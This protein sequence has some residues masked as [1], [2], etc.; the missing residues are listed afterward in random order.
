MP[1][2]GRN[3]G[4]VLLSAGW[5]GTIGCSAPKVARQATAAGPVRAL[6]S[7]AAAN[8]VVE[9]TGQAP[10]DQAQHIVTPVDGNGPAFQ[11]VQLVAATETQ[12][13]LPPPPEAVPPATIGETLA[14]ETPE[15]QPVVGANFPT[16]LSLAAGRNPQVAFA[17]SRIVE[18]AAQLQGARAL[19]LPSINVGANYNKH[20]GAIQDV[21]GNMIETTRGSLYSGLGSMAVGASSPAVPGIVARFRLTDA[22][23]EPRITDRLLAANQYGSR[24]VLNDVLLSAGIAYTDLLSA[25][26]FEAIAAETLGHAETLAHLT[27][28]YARTGLGTE[29]D[30]NRLATE[31]AYRRN[32]AQRAREAMQVAS[33]R[34]ARVLSQDPSVLIVPQEPNIFPIDMV[35]AGQSTQELVATALSNR[36]ELA[37]S[38]AL[39]AASVE[40]L[41][42]EVRAPWLP[43]ILLAASYGGNGGGLGDNL[44]RFGDRIDLDAGMWWEIRNSGFGESAARGAARAR[45]DQARAREIQVLDQVASE[46]AEAHVQSVSRR[47][48]IAI[49]EGGVQEAAQS[50][51]RNLQ[52]IREGQGLPI[53]VLQSMQAQDQARRELLRT[54]TDYNTAQ[55]RLQRALGWPVGP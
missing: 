35:P 21:V 30:A 51:E 53:E 18:S 10:F 22:L 32:E 7:P 43:S 38:K 47:E 5:L 37:E 3:L 41:R 36:P 29:A 48:Q 46:A 4:F 55:L 34:L 13:P 8:K 19:W 15:G 9:S 54:I 40:R 45:I 33:V 20:E 26:Q 49:A 2:L 17:N 16:V 27:A 31:L 23:S 24:A 39:V 42:R 25:A 52:R 44:E 6:A 1:P 50:F 14:A 12:E 28:E 11:P